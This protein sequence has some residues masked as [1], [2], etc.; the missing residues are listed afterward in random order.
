MSKIEFIPIHFSESFSEIEHRLLFILQRFN[1]CK[2][3]I[4]RY[5]IALYYKNTCVMYVH[6]YQM[7]DFKNDC[8]TV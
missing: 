2:I 3:F 8:I 7:A 1:S 5:V 6:L 4:I